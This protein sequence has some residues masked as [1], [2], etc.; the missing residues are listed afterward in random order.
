MDAERTA[1]RTLDRLLG[2]RVSLLQPTRGY[3]VAIDPVLLAAAVD[4]DEGDAVLD[5]GA[6]TGGAA[7]CLAARVGGCS[8]VGLERDPGLAALA[9]GSVELNREGDRVRILEGD[10]LAPPAPLRDRT[11][12]VVM[13]NPPYLDAARSRGPDDAGRADAHLEDV[14][15]DRWVDACLRR[16]RPG[17][18]IALV[19]RADRLDDILAALRGRAGDIVVLPLWPRSGAAAVRVIVRARK[20]ARGPLRLAAGLVL[21]EADGG[22]TQAASAILREGQALRS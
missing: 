20:G 16:L 18:R 4:A 3:R 21:H 15:L 12:D 8:I 2:G 6:G 5:S 14:T 19:H 22:F 7:L 13:S 1:E 10:L 11:F 17:G 9:R